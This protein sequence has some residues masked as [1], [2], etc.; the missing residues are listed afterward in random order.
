MD[1]HVRKTITTWDI[2]TPPMLSRLH[3]SN[4]CGS[5]SLK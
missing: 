2:I 3:L 4:H 1:E 5:D